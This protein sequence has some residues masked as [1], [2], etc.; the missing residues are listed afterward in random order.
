MNSIQ[1]TMKESITRL[2]ALA[3]KALGPEKVNAEVA[4]AAAKECRNHFRLLDAS[5]PNKLGGKRTHFFGQ[6]AK[7]I[8][9]RWD[10]AKAVVAISE[11]QTS[12]PGKS[13]LALHYFGGTVRPTRSKFL[14][15]PAVPEAHGVRA[16]EA[17]WAGKLHFAL[18]GG[19]HPALVLRDNEGK[20]KK[21]L[22]AGRVIYW[23]ARSVTIKA[24]KEVLP[25]EAV[26]IAAAHGA[27]SRIVRRIATGGS[28][29]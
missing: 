24:D 3:A 4:N 12:G 2:F 19:K 21:R 25:S 1:I 16:R 7:T 5:R 10:A 14:T 11:P 23:L 27:I 20:G 8:T 28:P 13:P 29:A 18:V 26:L 9:P 22:G 17:Q 6:Y 15:I